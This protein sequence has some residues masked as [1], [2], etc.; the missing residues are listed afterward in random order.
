MSIEKIPVNELKDNYYVYGNKGNV[1][2]DTSHIYES[3]HGVLCGVHALST[4][5][6]KYNEVT[7]VGCKDCIEKYKNKEL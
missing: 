2:S 7:H 5:W 3:G 4:N 6:A 1:W